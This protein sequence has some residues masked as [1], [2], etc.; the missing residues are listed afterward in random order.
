[1]SRRKEAASED[2]A[3]QP[4]VS[5]LDVE[6]ASTPAQ[7][8]LPDAESGAGSRSSEFSDEPGTEVAL[9]AEVQLAVDERCRA[10]GAA[11][12][13]SLLPQLHRQSGLPDSVAGSA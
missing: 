1:R 8:G 3:M 7:L 10:L 4:R 5:G 9:L 13:A 2:A 11:T 12:T 6:S